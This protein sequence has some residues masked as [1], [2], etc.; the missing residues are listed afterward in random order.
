M[1]CKDLEKRIERLESRSYVTHQELIV[2][3]AEVKVEA[4]TI[5]AR[6]SQ[7]RMKQKQSMLAQKSP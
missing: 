6:N 1:S 2:L 4:R 3:L 7:E 5:N